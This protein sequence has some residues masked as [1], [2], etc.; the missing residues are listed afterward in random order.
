VGSPYRTPARAEIVVKSRPFS[1]TLMWLVWF[2]TIASVLTLLIAQNVLTL[3]I[4]C[5]ALALVTVAIAFLLAR[6][7]TRARFEVVL[8]QETLR[9]ERVTR[10]ERDEIGRLDVTSGV[11]VTVRLAESDLDLD[12]VVFL[13]NERGHIAFQPGGMTGEVAEQLLRF[14]RSRG[15]DARDRVPSGPLGH[16]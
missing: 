14:L 5:A 6:M 1:G 3:R 8:E 15:I 9:I 10:G 12:G 13:E 16:H 2:A 4:L 11:D 7:Q